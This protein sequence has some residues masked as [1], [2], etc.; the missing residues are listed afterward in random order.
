M[1]DDGDGWSDTNETECGDGENGRVNDRND[2]DAKGTYLRDDD[3]F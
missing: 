1:T 2:D 3:E